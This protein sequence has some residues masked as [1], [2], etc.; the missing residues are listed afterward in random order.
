MYISPSHIIEVSYTQGEQFVLPNNSFYKGAYHK[1][2]SGNFWTGEI[3]TNQSIKLKNILKSVDI[4]LNHISKNNPISKDYTKHYKGNLDTTFIKSD[5]IKPNEQ[6]YNVGYFTR[7]VAQ[8]KA[9]IKPELN[10]FEINKTTFD[11]VSKEA[12]VIKYYKLASFKW[13][14]IGPR[15]DVYEGNVRIESGVEDTNLRSLQDVDRIITN[16]KLFITDPLQFTAIKDQIELG[17]DGI[18]LID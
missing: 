17:P 6:D 1:D 18:V 5:I 3:H 7:Y 13:K 9:S 16:I 2:S 4:D 11:K 14:L 10:T 8:L 12:N 15:F